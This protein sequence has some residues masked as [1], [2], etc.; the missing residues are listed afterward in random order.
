MLLPPRV[1]RHTHLEGSLAPDWV[2]LEAAR[3][4]L[5]VPDLTEAFWRGEAHSFEAFIATFVFACGFLT[6]S[7]AVAVALGAAVKRLP[8][9]EPGLPRGIDLW[10]SP[11]WLVKERR[12]I[13]LAHLWKG[14]EQG[15]ETA[16]C[17]G[18][19]VAV[20]I[21]AVNHFGP[22]HGHEVL[23]LVLEELPPW[24]VGFSTGG[25]EKVPFREWAPVFERARK[26]GLRLAA[27]AGE[28]G[29]ASRIR[30]AILEA[31]VQRI[32][33]AVRAVEDPSI[34]ELLAERQIP[35]DVCLTSN[36]AL[37]PGLDHHPLPSFLAAGIRCGL[38]TDDPGVM[39]CDL[40]GEWQRAM[41][42]GISPEAAQRL[43]EQSAEDAWCFQIGT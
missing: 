4:H 13:S 32:V 26:A 3:R 31:G 15:I 18:V 42:T 16:R 6:S 11:H 10:I 7:E 29:P 20:V 5:S 1:D 36:H 9:P 30:E 2:R 27:H 43:Q 8:P 37:V 28:N 19:R 34:L 22:A 41:G 40:P 25:M 14:L 23:D 12:Q 39:L 21:D 38:G 35:V 33:H 17:Q 24:V